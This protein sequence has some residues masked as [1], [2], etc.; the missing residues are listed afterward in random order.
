MYS[1]FMWQPVRMGDE[2]MAVLVVSVPA[3]LP[4]Q[5]QGYRMRDPVEFIPS[6]IQSK[7]IQLIE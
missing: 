2:A 5:G 1:T 7:Q 6:F 4:R 3:Y